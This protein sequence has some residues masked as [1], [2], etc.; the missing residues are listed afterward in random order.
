MKLKNIELKDAGEISFHCGDLKDHCQLTVKECDKPP[1]IDASRFS[2][3]VTVKAGRPLDLE[4]PY[5][6]YPPPTMSWTKDGKTIQ[7]G[8]DT[9]CKMTLEPRRCCLNM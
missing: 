8:S 7:P 9:P 1:R 6:A 3:S 5:E 4:I 2:K